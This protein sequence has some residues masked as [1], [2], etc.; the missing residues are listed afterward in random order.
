MSFGLPVNRPEPVMSV[1]GR[2]VCVLP[3][4]GNHEC[5]GG[6]M[7]RTRNCKAVTNSN[8][9]TRSRFFRVAILIIPVML[10]STSSWVVAHLATLIRIAVCPR[11]RVPPH[12]QGPN[13]SGY[14]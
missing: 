8:C 14:L 2:I 4:F 3:R 1:Y 6:V 9:H 10:R 7:G 13:R 11:H 12:Q 5:E